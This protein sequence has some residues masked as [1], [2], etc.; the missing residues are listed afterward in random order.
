MAEI[1]GHREREVTVPAGVKPG[2]LLSVQVPSATK[3]TEEASGST[4]EISVSSNNAAGEAAAAGAVATVEAKGGTLNNDFSTVPVVFGGTPEQQ[5]AANAVNAVHDLF[6]KEQVKSKKWVPGDTQPLPTL[7]PLG[8]TTTDHWT[9]DPSVYGDMTGL[10]AQSCAARC[11]EC[12]KMGGNYYCQKCSDVCSQV[13]EAEEK[14]TSYSWKPGDPRGVIDPITQAILPTQT[15]FFRAVTKEE[16]K[17][18]MKPPMI[19]AKKR[20]YQKTTQV[21]HVNPAGITQIVSQPEWPVQSTPY[22]PQTGLRTAGLSALA[23]LYKPGSQLPSNLPTLSSLETVEGRE[24]KRSLME[25]QQKQ[26]ILAEENPTT[27]ENRGEQTATPEKR[28]GFIVAAPDDQGLEHGAVSRKMTTN[29]NVIGPGGP[30]FVQIHTE[31]AENP[32]HFGAYLRPHFRSEYPTTKTIT[33]NPTRSVI[34]VNPRPVIAV[35]HAS[36]TSVVNMYQPASMAAKQ[37]TIQTTMGTGGLMFQVPAAPGMVLDP[38]TAYSQTTTVNREQP[39]WGSPSVSSTTV[40]TAAQ[41]APVQYVQASQPLVRYIQ[42]PATAPVQYVQAPHGGWSTETINGLPPPPSTPQ[43]ITQAGLVPPALRAGAIRVVGAVRP[44]VQVVNKDTAPT[45]QSLSPIPKLNPMPFFDKKRREKDAIFR[46]WDGK[47]MKVLNVLPVKNGVVNL[48]PESWQGQNTNNVIV[49]EGS[50]GERADKKFSEA[51]MQIQEGMH[52]AANSELHFKGKDRTTVGY[53][54]YGDV[55]PAIGEPADPTRGG[56][57][58]I[59]NDPFGLRDKEAVSPLASINDR[60]GA[61]PTGSKLESMVVKVPA[62]LSAG[63]KFTALT[64]AGREE[65]VIVPQGVK[66][67]GEVEISVPVFPT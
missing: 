54:E 62:G 49:S 13:Y 56:P 38:G 50:A 18:M 31:P 44:S 32:Q 34:A 42:R 21:T 29:V 52:A 33:V 28:P 63:Q 57:K 55:N 7:M 43:F 27:A 30:T 53:R 37:Q 3:L 24:Y 36:S 1:P 15:R 23:N 4:E 8:Q 14:L 48:D 11:G 10:H 45:Y 9:S 61:V 65:E 58:L 40:T 19:P 60:A 51:I 35:G 20:Y 39:Q 2:Q 46:H 22:D 67:G 17:N 6:H 26:Q 12:K 41:G 64:G 47:E 25:K 66:A 59:T 5:A 16:A